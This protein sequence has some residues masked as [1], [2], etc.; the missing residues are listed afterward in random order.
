MN[1]RYVEAVYWSRY[2]ANND[3]RWYKRLWQNPT[4]PAILRAKYKSTPT[5]R[6]LIRNL[7]WTSPAEEQWTADNFLN[8]VK[9]HTSFK[10]E[11]RI[12][13]THPYRTKWQKLRDERIPESSL[14]WW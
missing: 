1:K 12:K 8:A 11:L 3:Y 5:V 6:L 7:R 10:T 9:G 2:S 14:H 13:I 4:H